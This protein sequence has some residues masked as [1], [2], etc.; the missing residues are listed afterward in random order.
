MINGRK[1]FKIKASED[2]DSHYISIFKI[3]FIKET[4]KWNGVPLLISAREELAVTYNRLV[5]K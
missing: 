4:S 5:S 3:K 2:F 1:W